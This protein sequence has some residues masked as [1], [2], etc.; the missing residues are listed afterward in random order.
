MIKSRWPWSAAWL[1][2]WLLGACGSS[3]HEVVDADVVDSPRIDAALVD[4]VVD[5]VP[6]ALVLD[7]AP[8]A[9][10]FDAAPDAFVVDASPLPDAFVLDAALPPDALVLDATALPDAA[11]PIDAAVPV[12]AAVPPGNTRLRLVAGNIS[13]GN[14]QAYELPGIRIFQGLAPDVAMIQEFNVTT[15]TIRGFIDQAFGAQFSFVRGASGQQIPNGVI[16]RYPILASG[17]WTDTEVSN[18]DFVW[19]RIDVP[20]PIDLFAISVHLLTANAT[21]RNIE[22]G[23]LAQH[24]HDLPSNAYIV[25]GGDFNTDTRS[26]PALTTLAPVLVTAG[27]NPADLNG[28]GNTN[29]NRNKPYDWVLASPALDALETPTTI[30]AHQFSDG[31][32]AD[33]RVYTPIGDLAPA[34]ASDSAA[35]NMQ[36]MAIVRDFLL[37][38]S[39]AP[40]LQV[41][42]PNGGELWQAGTT[43][44]IT[45]TASGVANVRVELITGTTIWEISASTPAI[46]GQVTLTVPP[47]VTSAA[48]A[49]ITEVG[50]SL[51]DT[52]DAAFS[53]AIA[54]PPDGRAF[55][56]EVL[57]NEPGSDVN[58]EFIEL[59]N[60]GTSDAD[61]SGWT[62]SDAV[63]VRHTFAPGTVLRAGRALAVFGGASGIPA[64]L[65]NAIAASTG[66]LNLGNGGDTVTLASPSGTVDSVTYTSVLS[67]TD[68]VSMNRNPDG[69]GAGT[70]VLHTVLTT[71]LRSPGVRTTGAAF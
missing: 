40:S 50:G 7:A 59:V 35:T 49:R 22:A 58:G 37:P 23:E 25:L 62:L 69:D 44:T 21:E 48:F 43:R 68:G 14:A 32:V 28:S 53:I 26:E 70:F 19:A 2:I 63:M 67:G 36:H 64:G 54:P 39:A 4:A 47:V 1:A 38:G 46:D 17:E 33:T 66:G 13:S 5:P 9:T 55:I 30:G 24:I 31:F 16:S 15:G 12:D 29:A 51:S 45:W 41:T 65:G 20:G 61:L 11:V 56:N 27:P 57:A 42:S 8:D 60:T 18:R 6:D 52:S 71:A 10:L 34:L 3:A